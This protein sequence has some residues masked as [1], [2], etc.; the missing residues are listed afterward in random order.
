[1]DKHI[2]DLTSLDFFQYRVEHDSP[3]FW[4]IFFYIEELTEDICVNMYVYE[5]YNLT[6]G[7]FEIITTDY[8][9]SYYTP[10]KEHVN[11]EFL[12]EYNSILDYG[13]MQMNAYS[14]HQTLPG[15]YVPTGLAL[16]SANGFLYTYKI[17]KLRTDTKEFQFSIF[18][19]ELGNQIPIV[20]YNGDRKFARLLYHNQLV[21]IQHK[22]DNIW[23]NKAFFSGLEGADP[24]SPPPKASNSK[25]YQAAYGGW[26]FNVIIGMVSGDCI[27]PELPVTALLNRDDVSPCFAFYDTYRQYDNLYVSAIQYQILKVCGGGPFGST[28]CAPYDCY[29][30]LTHDI[31]DYYSIYAKNIPFSHPTLSNLIKHHDVIFMSEGSETSK[32]YSSYYCNYWFIVAAGFNYTTTI[33]HT[34]FDYTIT[35]SG[36]SNGLRCY[37]EASNV[38]SPEAQDLYYK[39]QQLYRYQQLRYT[40]VP[41]RF[42]QSDL[43]NGHI[44]W[45]I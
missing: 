23:E 28:F 13:Y 19:G 20:G 11:K 42:E 9:E 30:E 24:P 29:I 5:I 35:E 26:T 21:D 2:K 3:E 44:E 34:L 33:K 7:L 43:Q 12:Y 14:P 22:W 8:S 32:I 38:L 39:Y 45:V 40:C 16:A 10:I 36:F 18:H 15:Y 4:K 1:M 41:I 27:C 31:D 37:P 25:P 17:D 6:N